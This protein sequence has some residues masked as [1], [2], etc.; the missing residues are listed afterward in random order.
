MVVWR[1]K[2]W[3]SLNSELLQFAALKMLWKGTPFF[4]SLKKAF[5]HWKIYVYFDFIYL[6]FLWYLFHK[7]GLPMILYITTVFRSKAH[8]NFYPFMLNNCFWKAKKEKNQFPIGEKNERIIKKDVR[9]SDNIFPLTLGTKYKPPSSL[10][11]Q[12]VHK[13]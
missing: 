11:V 6:L 10:L 5:T 4:N 8:T 7:T 2:K 1:C 13:V 12:K 9:S 3:S